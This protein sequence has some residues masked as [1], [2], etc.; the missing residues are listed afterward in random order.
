MN[1]IN[2]LTPDIDPTIIE[3]KSVVILIG[4]T[5]NGKSAC[6]NRMV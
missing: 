6:A 1:K 5:G 4:T 2:K 3:N